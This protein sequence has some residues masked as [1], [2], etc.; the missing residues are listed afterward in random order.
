MESEAS[1]GRVLDRPYF[2]LAIVLVV[3]A[4]LVFISVH[5]GMGMSEFLVNDAGPGP[6]FWNVS[7]MVGN[8]QTHAGQQAAA[9][10]AAAAAA[11]AQAA[12]T[13]AATTQAATAAAASAQVAA[14]TAQTASATAPPAV[15]A[16]AAQTAVAA[17]NAAQVASSAAV[18]AANTATSTAAEYFASSRRMNGH[19]KREF[20]SGAMNK[21]KSKLKSVM[22][23]GK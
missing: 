20:M 19:K 18:Q 23:M 15:A 10:N 21:V 11:A 9:A 12:T 17:S 2:R 16:Q 5:A 1:V 8:Y 14:I 6:D 13:S 4:L 22:G 3:L 7:N